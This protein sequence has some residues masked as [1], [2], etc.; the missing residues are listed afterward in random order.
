MNNNDNPIVGYRAPLNCLSLNYRQSAVNAEGMRVMRMLS[1]V[2]EIKSSQADD[3]K[4]TIILMYEE[5]SSIEYVDNS[6]EWIIQNNRDT[7]SFELSDSSDDSSHLSIDMTNVQV[8]DFDYVDNTCIYDYK[9]M[10]TAMSLMY[11]VSIDHVHE[12]HEQMFQYSVLRQSD[13]D[14]MKE[15]VVPKRNRLISNLTQMEAM[16]WTRFK[17]EQ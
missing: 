4:M 15:P 2:S 3:I 5:M 1:D 16:N 11:D 14:L 12:L 9:D 7:D 17:K 13:L 6:S 10:I 8:N